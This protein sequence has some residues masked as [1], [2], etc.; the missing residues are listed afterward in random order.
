MAAVYDA[1]MGGLANWMLFGGVL[2]VAL[3]AAAATR[4]PQPLERPRRVLAWFGRAP[5]STWARV[6][7]ALLVGLV[8]IVAFLEPTLALQII[9]VWAGAVAI[10]YA[11]IELI[12]TI[13][14]AAKAVPA[15]GRGAR[16]QVPPAASWRTP[17]LAAATIVAV[18]A[19]AAF[20]ITDEDKGEAKRPVGSVKNCNGY[21]P[22]CDRALVDV[23][24]PGHPQRHVR[25]RAARLV[26]AESAAR[27]PAPAKRGCPRIPD[28]LPL[29]D[30]ALQRARSHRPEPARTRARS[31]RR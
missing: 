15:K 23:V 21:A 26:R 19:V 31:T 27:D 10:Y 24:L 22:L 16:K 17:A 9:A 20:V 3:A 25:G 8:G 7:R 30:Q 28:R 1:Y 5:D 18:A 29:R 13:A 12:A 2:A 14:P 4:D 11:V 6:V